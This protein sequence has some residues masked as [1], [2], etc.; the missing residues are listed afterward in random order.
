MIMTAYPEARLDVAVPDQVYLRRTFDVAAAVRLRDSPLLDEDGLPHVKSGPAR[1]FW[2]ESQDH[3]RMCLQIIAPECQI[4]GDDQA[5]FLLPKGADSPVFYFNLIPLH[6]GPITIIIKLWQEYDILGNARVRTTA[7]DQAAGEVRLAVT[8]QAVPVDFSPWATVAQLSPGLPPA[9][10]ERLRLTLSQSPYLA[11]GA[12]LHT[13][14]VDA[15][16]TPWRD[17]IPDNTPSRTARVNGLIHTLYA[18]TNTAGENALVL[19][20]H[21]LADHTDPDD[22]LHPQ[23]LSLAADLDRALT[24]KPAA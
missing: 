22:A 11:S 14:F 24:A 1:I 6:L 20:L 2:P 5:T 4:I 3:V 23:L 9:L 15:R 16:L 17:H 7:V 13:L 8:S 18:K 10:N 19:F 12:A 21:V